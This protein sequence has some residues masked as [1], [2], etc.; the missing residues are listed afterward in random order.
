MDAGRMDGRWMGSVMRKD[1]LER[2]VS[3]W[4]TEG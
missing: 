4:I 3:G 1:G 2:W